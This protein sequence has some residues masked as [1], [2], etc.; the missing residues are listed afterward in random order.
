[1]RKERLSRELMN[2]IARISAHGLVLV[3]ATFLGL[4]LGLYLDK[5]TNMAPNFTLV[6]LVIGVV[7]GFRGF[8]QEVIRE[9]RG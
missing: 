9:R 1:M 4:Y 2:K 3:V 8:V 5:V 7:L 6:F